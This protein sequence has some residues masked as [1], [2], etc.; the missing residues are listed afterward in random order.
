MS[1][2]ARNVG[3]IQSKMENGNQSSLALYS[4]KNMSIQ[5]Q[6]FSSMGHSGFFY[7]GGG[8]VLPIRVL[9]RKGKQP[10]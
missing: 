1:S 6:E 5:G 3:I 10:L 9:S 8:G 4:V 2:N 7:W